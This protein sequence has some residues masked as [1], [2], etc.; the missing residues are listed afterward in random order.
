MA[1]PGEGD[2]PIH[3]ASSSRIAAAEETGEDESAAWRETKTVGIE[4][5]EG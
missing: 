1:K 5:A 3:L 2:R 4:K